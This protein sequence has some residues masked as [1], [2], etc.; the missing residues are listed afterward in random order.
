[1]GAIDRTR[2][3]NRAGAAYTLCF[4]VADGSAGAVVAAH[5][6]VGKDGPPAWQVADDA[7]IFKVIGAGGGWHREAKSG[8]CR[9][10]R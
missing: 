1:M 4:P 10:K 7:T 6:V 5:F 3:A 8:D 2:V 9:E